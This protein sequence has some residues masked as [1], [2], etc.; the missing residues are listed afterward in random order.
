MG[1]Y[2]L[3]GA[4]AVPLAQR[5]ADQG[6]VL[7]FGFNPAE[8]ARSFAAATVLDPDCAACW[9]GLAWALGPTINADT[10]PDDVP[11][12]EQAVARAVEHA[13]RA[14]PRMRDLIAALAVR[15]PRGRP[16]DE[17]GYAERM[18]LLAKRYPDDADV[19]FLAG[20]SILNLHPYDW[21]E[22]DGRAKPW[23]PEIEQLFGEALERDPDHPGANHYVVHLYESSR[24]PEKGVPSADRL[25]N[26]VPG[27]G[28]LLHMP[29]HVYMR[30][31]RY[32][33]ASAANRRSIAADVRYLAQVDAQ[34]AY[35]VGYVAHNHHFL[36]ASAAMQGRSK[37]AI[38]AAGAAWPAACGPKPG[39][40]STAILQHYYALPLYARV[41]FGKW[42]ELLTDTLPPDVAE[43]YPMAV[44][45]YARGTAL[46]RKGRQADAR[47]ALERLDRIAADPALKDAR[48]KN[49]NAAAVLARIA[50]LTL[51]ADLEWSNRRPERAT[52]LLAQA[53]ALEDGLTYDEPHL[54]LAP[55]R[56]ALGAAL[57]AEGRGR[58]AERVYREDLAHY[59]ENGWSLTGLARA[60]RMQ[61]RN[62]AAKDVDTRVREAWRDADVPITASRF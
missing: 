10:A 56:H 21:W 5:Y 36:W 41:R 2:R 38:E 57:L 55:T 3:V 61:G 54:W 52:P 53:V 25:V 43:P 26:L 27:S 28:H 32:A 46:V 47:A 30:T 13:K 1:R 45:H 58:D 16:I 34:G 24:T 39:D 8:A 7:A 48:I 51:R 31:G 15:H 18:R 50:A 4:S 14:T 40:R 37:E 23:T 11:R 22:R 17:Q 62:E 42:D 29:A 12:V 60:L 20:E 35:R 44:W 19:L 9:W 59:P 6:M 49:I 33:E